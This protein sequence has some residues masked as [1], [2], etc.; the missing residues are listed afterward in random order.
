[1][2]EPILDPLLRDRVADLE[3]RIGRVELRPQTIP[4]AYAEASGS[5]AGISG[6]TDVAGL[7]RTV[8]V[9]S[10]RLLRLSAYVHYRYATTGG[11]VQVRILEPAVGGVPLQRGSDSRAVGE[12]GTLYIAAIVAPTAGPHTYGVSIWPNPA[13][14]LDIES[15][16]AAPSYLFIED[17]GLAPA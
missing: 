6:H 3:A 14:T 13:G 5:Q 15:T 8:T 7:S 16:S 17:V 10:R 11:T 9:G 12:Y 2:G 4:L 1:M